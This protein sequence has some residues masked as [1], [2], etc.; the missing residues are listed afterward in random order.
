M[1]YCLLAAT[2]LSDVD[3][4]IKN[5]ESKGHEVKV[6]VPLDTLAPDVIIIVSTTWFC[7]RCG[8]E[9]SAKQMLE[10]MKMLEAR[11]HK[12]LLSTLEHC[13]GY[14]IFEKY[15]AELEGYDYFKW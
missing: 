14:D 1:I 8:S 7:W 15:R 13:G 11:G 10:T 2:S 3:D 4:F 12:V 9:T 6:R 5:L